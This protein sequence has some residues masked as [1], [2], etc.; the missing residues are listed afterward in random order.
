M[1]KR[2]S[3]SGP[4]P[5]E[6]SEDGLNEERR[7]DDVAIDKVGKI[8]E[9]ANVVA[10]DFEASTAL[11][12]I[13]KNVFNVGEG[14]LEDKVFHALDLLFFPVITPLYDPLGHRVNG[15]VH[16]SHVQRTHLG[17][18]LER[19]SKPFLNLHLSTAARRDVDDG[20]CTFRQSGANLLEERRIS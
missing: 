7:L 13:A 2:F 4:R 17:L 16:R 6:N 5:P 19:I 3:G 20:V 9:V 12:K 14:I 11:S 18:D 10:L 1:T 15:K 8:I